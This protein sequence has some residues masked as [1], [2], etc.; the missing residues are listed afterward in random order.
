MEH[1]IVEFLDILITNIFFLSE[2]QSDELERV[3]FEI[4]EI[5][6]S[7]INSFKQ[8]EGGD[9]NKNNVL[10]RILKPEGIID[11]E[12]KLSHVN[13]IIDTIKS[14][15]IQKY[16]SKRQF[17]ELNLENQIRKLEDA[18]SKLLSKNDMI[19][20]EEETS[21]NISSI[22]QCWRPFHNISQ[23]SHNEEL[24]DVVRYFKSV[25]EEFD[26][27]SITVNSTYLSKDFAYN[28]VG[29]QHLVAKRFK[30]LLDTSNSNEEEII[31][32]IKDELIEIGNMTKSSAET[33]L[34]S[35]MDVNRLNFF[36]FRIPIE[37]S[38]ILYKN[39][40]VQLYCS[41]F[42]IISFPYFNSLGI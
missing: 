28:R 42:F 41:K 17:I 19:S 30:D 35:H 25:E 23:C 37:V 2:K 6:I 16:M 18:F 34:N 5:I 13:N 21:K 8:I 29:L 22:L 24:L 31:E 15:I 14:S 33:L 7:I 32:R 3:L 20:N 36:K 11:K 39:Q 1:D 12:T 40:L 9:K 26:L 27:I 38:M 10:N 4:V